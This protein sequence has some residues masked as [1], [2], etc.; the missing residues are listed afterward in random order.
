MLEQRLPPG[1]PHHVA[2]EQQSHSCPDSSADAHAVQRW[3]LCSVTTAS[4]S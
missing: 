2:A 4:S 3:T 1:P